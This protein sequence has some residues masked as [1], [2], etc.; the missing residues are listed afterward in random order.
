MAVTYTSLL[1]LAKPT[2]GTE[3]GT[4]GDVVND[5]LTTY[6]DSA[7]AGTQTISGTQTAVALSITTG[8]T[9]LVQAAA[10]SAGSAQYQIINCTGTPTPTGTLVI[11]APAFSK[12]YL[13]IN[14]TTNNQSVTVKASATTGVTIP[15]L[16]RSLI[17]WNGS[18]Y[19]LIASNRITDLTGTLTTGNGG[20]G[21]T[22]F[23]A[24]NNAIYSTSSSALTAGTLPL[25]AGGTGATTQQ[26][27]INALA[28]ATTSAQYLRGNGTN[29]VMSAIQVADVPTLNQNT[30]GNAGTVTNGVYT[31][32]NQTISGTKTFSS[33]VVLGSSTLAPSGSAPSY[34]ARVW[35]N[36]NGTGTVAIRASGNVTS[37][38]DNGIGD[39]TV[40]FTTAL[41]DA[42]YSIVVI[43]CATTD[44]D[45]STL[46]GAQLYGPTAL[47]TTSAR[48]KMMN[49]L[50]D[51]SYDSPIACIS[52]FR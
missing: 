28:G 26:T 12:V 19:I 30:T 43:G 8:G 33:G 38:T 45:T 18:D 25:A 9:P 44:G 21:L 37:I 36:F 13:V 15:A 3:A 47:A 6:L 32:G 34:A 46:R 16:T 20:T 41:A 48:I 11:T 17:A 14:A 50:N 42:D 52:V 40:N 5:Y 29:V 23:T 2:T 39:Y 22:T 4:W 31:T 24:A 49:G 27:A 7:I 51:Q 35:V 1:G 10:T